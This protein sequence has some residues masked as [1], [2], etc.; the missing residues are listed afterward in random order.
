TGRFTQEDPIGLAGGQNLYGFASGD[1]VNFADPF[2]LQ[3]CEQGA[4]DE[5]KKSVD[6]AAAAKQ[7][8]SDRLDDVVKMVGGAIDALTPAGDVDRVISGT[9]FLSGAHLSGAQRVG[10]GLMAM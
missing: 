8:L 10:A 2:G 5:C 1:P 3:G 9:D 6:W 4:T 7:W